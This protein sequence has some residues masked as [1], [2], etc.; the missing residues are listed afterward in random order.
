M[1]KILDQ[2]ESLAPEDQAL[3]KAELQARSASTRTRKQIEQAWQD[4]LH[5]GL[6]EIKHGTAELDDWEDVER[7]L[8][9]LTGD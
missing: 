6:R 9:E 8:T 5:Q 4:D 1:A 2:I 7:E 3:L